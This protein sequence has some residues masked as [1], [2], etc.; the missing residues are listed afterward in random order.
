[1]PF[2]FLFLALSQI[3]GILFSSFVPVSINLLISLLIVILLCA[4]VFFFVGKNKLAFAS[5]LLSTFLLGASLFT[6]SSEKFDRNQLHNWKHTE[7][8]DF[9][10]KLYKSQ[11]RGLAKDFLYVKVHRVLY[12]NK[13][14]KITGNLRVTIPHSQ[15]PLTDLNLYAGDTIKISAKLFTSPGFRNFK[16]DSLD[17]YLKSQN[18]H[19]MAFTK[20]PLLINKLESRKKIHPQRLLSVIRK[21]MQ[22]KIEQHFSVS[23]SG[24]TSS[25]GAILEALLLGERRRMDPLITQSLQKSGLYHL[26]AISGAH[27]AIISFLLF[28]VLRLIRISTRLSYALVLIN[29]ILFALLV[30]GRPSVIRATIMASAFLLGKL[31]WKNV[32]LLNT[33]SMSA[34]FILFLNPL[35]LFSLGF[36]LTF[37]ATFSILLFFPQ[38][39]KY[40]PK[41]PWR[42]SEILCLSLT[43]QIGVLPLIARTFNRITFS[44]LF[45][46]F[47]ALPL[48]GL[49][50]GCGFI[51]LPLS[52]FSPFLAQMLAKG[53]NFLINILLKC[54]HLLDWVPSISY[55]I[56]TPHTA[57]IFGY[58]LFLLFLLLPL[59]IKWQK[60]TTFFCFL[61]FL[62]ILITY[63]FPS[64]SS[65][66]KVSFIDVGQGESM[67]IEFPGYKKMLVDGGGFPKNSYDI[68][69]R[70]VSPFLWSKGIKKID[71]LVLTHAHPDHLNGLKSI[72]NN[73]KIGEFWEAC[74]PSEDKN[75]E[76]FITLLPHSVP[77]KR[78]FRGRS[79]QVGD[80]RI[81]AFHPPRGDPYVSTIYNNQSLVLKM[82]HGHISFLLTGDIE[83]KAEE[84]ISKFST[85]L[86]S[87]ILKSPHHGS[88]SSSSTAFLQAVKPR[89]VVISAS[90]GNIYGFPH[91]EILERYKRFGIKIYRTD[92]HGAVEISSDGH[93]ISVRTA[94]EE[95]H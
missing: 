88:R 2:P 70:V 22:E 83:A 5:I 90:K 87:Q 82:T 61:A 48:V 28:S 77:R 93:R 73:F 15:K 13:D 91:K 23:D 47:A 69:E 30:E 81:E 9:Y 20:S 94:T 60:L 45:L 4:W 66:L 52:F 32:H 58:F 78:V 3:L 46:N 92:N 76:E 24:T 14:K 51:F 68:G 40:L 79:F 37:T 11:S 38:I 41:L 80:I 39:I 34:F 50:M 95:S 57:T 36:Q 72:V 42:I 65:S 55:R 63:P 17:K 6:H 53:I 71:F 89:L 43:A 10:G 18:I 44:S 7:Y 35:S 8:A 59:K 62:V 67:L 31:F 49:I 25:Q 26:F 75:Y 54:S 19:K 1:M 86:Q 29:L 64:H 21:K 84:Q 56:P 33:I 85:N 74:I 12:Q 16:K 27:I